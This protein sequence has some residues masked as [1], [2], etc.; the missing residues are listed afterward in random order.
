MGGFPS[1]LCLKASAGAGKT[2]RLT[3]EFLALL[4]SSPPHRE[5]L[6]QIVAITFTN[7]AAQ[8]MRERIIGELKRNA[9]GLQQGMGRELAR[10]WL[11]LI[12]E[13]YGDLQVRT[14]DS[15]VFTF[16]KALAFELG[17]QPELEVTFNRDEILD[18]CFDR[19]LA[20][21]QWGEG[22]ELERV[23]SE[24][25]RCFL[26]LEKRSGLKV[27]TSLRQRIKELFEKGDLTVSGDSDLEEMGRRIEELARRL[28]L[29]LKPTDYG[30]GKAREILEAPMRYL[31]RDYAFWRGRGLKGPS[32]SVKL[33]YLELIRLRDQ[34]LRERARAR[35]RP[36]VELLGHLREELDRMTRQ[37]GLLLGGDWNRLL[38]EH[39]EREGVPYALYK[40]GF[41][42]R[43]ILIDEFQD[44]ADSQWHTLRPII[45]NAL[46]EGGTLLYV[47]D[48]KQ[49]I[50]GWRGGNWRLLEGVLQEEFP[51][52]PPEGRRKEF[53]D[54]N[55]RSLREI[56][57]FNNRLFQPLSN[58]DWVRE[59]LKKLL[60]EDIPEGILMEFSR[61]LAAN[62]SDVQQKPLKGKGGRV[63][64]REFVGRK[65]EILPQ[66]REALLEE[67]SRS[68]RDR[69]RGIAILV[70]TNEQAEE[71]ACWLSESG[72]PVVTE[73]SLRL[74]RSP[75]IKGM[76]SL[77]K[78]LNYPGDDLALWG[79]LASGLLDDLQGLPRTEIETFLGQERGELSLYRAFRIRFPEGFSL[80]LE[81]LL[82]RVGFLAPYELCQEIMERLD[83]FGRFPQDTPILKRFLEVV[84]LAERS[85]VLS[86]PGFLEFWEREGAEQRI[87]I[88]EG[89][90]AVRI[91]TIHRAKGLEFPV[92][93]IPF[94]NW[95]LD[96][97]NIVRNERGE[98]LYL[99]NPLPQD[100]QILRARSRMEEILESLNLL[101]VATTRAVE[102]L[103]LYVTC[104]RSGNS[105][106][107]GYV[108]F[109]LRELLKAHEGVGEAEDR[110]P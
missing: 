26:E 28:L 109:I 22:S 1:I 30:R 41:P 10:G 103:H 11:E 20:R 15:L 45:E 19:I 53:L 79:A 81:P 86:L 39:L 52:V 42:I 58:I 85:G 54:R 91:M 65:E 69:S 100:L 72:I 5:R 74:R 76:V 99:T 8:E 75:L 17:R 84:F 18:R 38:K 88:P 57:E 27:E 110:D 36:Y 67:V 62:F 43:H 66:I 48:Q 93:F 64:R 24:L 107:R 51:S 4:S 97:P 40:L 61:A 9:L 3:R 71:V 80:Y 56:V 21:I 106:D 44:T 37:E 98:L 2:H 23:L 16:V 70:R 47:G 90:E 77:L 105:I 55:F 96:N 78:F 89:I 25:L 94:T 108:S 83:L 101:Y 68:F 31:D 63:I 14:I 35:L 32:G 49:A 13:R 50:Y 59:L 60:G 6:R 92:V 102:A 95:K 34:Y 104:Y 33:L 73:N 46:S 87:G 12:L 82:K 7:K 29:C